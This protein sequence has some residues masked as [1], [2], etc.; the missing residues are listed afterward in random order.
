MIKVRAAGYGQ[1]VAASVFG[2]SSN[3][4]LTVMRKIVI[5]VSL[6]VVVR[7]MRK[8]R[9]RCALNVPVMKRSILMMIMVVMLVM[10]VV[11]RNQH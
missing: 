2:Y 10:I 1:E 5:I 6:F 4:L 11:M 8:I 3:T 7:M 9:M